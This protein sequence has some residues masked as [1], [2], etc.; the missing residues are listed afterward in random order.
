LHGSGF[1]NLK[2]VEV[3]PIETLDIRQTEVLD[4][5]PLLVMK[6]LKKVIVSPSR[7]PESM[8]EQIRKVIT[9]AVE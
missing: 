9:V 6:D 3:L 4:L 7:F 5:V 2:E 1:F 8:L